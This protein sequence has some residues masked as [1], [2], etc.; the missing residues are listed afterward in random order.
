MVCIIIIVVII[1]VLVII[2][3]ARTVERVITTS[4][5]F[6]ITIVIFASMRHIQPQAN[7]ANFHLLGKGSLKFTAILE[8]DE[9]KAST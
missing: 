6:I 3:I 4:V 1:W 9:A 7:V 2:I 5:R 8:S